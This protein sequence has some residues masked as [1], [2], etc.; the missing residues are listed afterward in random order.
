MHITFRC[1]RV[2][3]E[4]RYQRIM[5]LAETFRRQANCRLPEGTNNTS[6]E[7]EEVLMD[8]KTCKR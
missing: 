2:F 6:S 1:S 7:A 3:I 4:G 5:H 8:Y